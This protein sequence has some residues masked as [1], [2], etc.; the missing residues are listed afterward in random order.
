MALISE[1]LLNFHI[2]E[3][4][5]LLKNDKN[6]PT[7]GAWMSNKYNW[8]NENLK[9]DYI[10]VSRNVVDDTDISIQSKGFYTILSAEVN[11]DGKCLI[12]LNELK[13]LSN[14]S[15]SQVTAY[16]RELKGKGYLEKTG[17]L[18]SLR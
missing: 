14:R 13:N 15:T 8:H 16:I 11:E 5:I 1:E 6:I 18:V 10:I 2:Q 4:S 17:R 9:N 12:S 3:Y 7:F